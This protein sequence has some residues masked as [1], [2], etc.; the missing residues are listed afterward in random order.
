MKTYLKDLL[1]RLKKFSSSL[2]QTAML[3]DKPWVVNAG[4]NQYQKLI[5]KKDGSLLLSRNGDLKDGK[6][7]YISG[8]NSIVIDYGTSKILYRHSFMDEAVLA[9][10]KDG[11]TQNDDEIFL[12]ANENIIPNADAILYL[13]NKVYREDGL[14]SLTLHNGKLLIVKERITGRIT[15]GTVSNY[16]DVISDGTYLSECRTKQYVISNGI[17]SRVFFK[18]PIS[19]TVFTWSHSAIPCVG[20]QVVGA[21]S[22]LFKSDNLEILVV[23][24]NVAKIKD[25]ERAYAFWVM[26]VLALI[27]IG[28]IIYGNL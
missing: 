18:V 1:P 8:A 16:S 27:T 23:N 2:D 11:P 21:V 10:R 6:W 3:T 24:G 14:S 12:L 4:N 22:G 13:K 28:A 15:E 19:D 17:V 9:L 5:F 20:D 26:T 7:E 25:W